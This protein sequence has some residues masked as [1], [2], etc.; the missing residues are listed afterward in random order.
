MTWGGEGEGGWDDN[1]DNEPSI[2]TKAE[3]Y[4]SIMSLILGARKC[5]GYIKDSLMNA[6]PFTYRVTTTF[7]TC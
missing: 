6:E 4:D 3:L 1:L 2:E 5:N 7:K